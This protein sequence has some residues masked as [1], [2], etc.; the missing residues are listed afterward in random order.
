MSAAPLTI[1]QMQMKY[2]AQVSRLLVQGFRGKFQSLTNMKDDDLALFFEKLL[3]H[4][5]HEPFGRRM[6]VLLEGIVVGTM[7]IQWKGDSDPELKRKPLSWK[8]FNRFGKWNLMK[9]ML[10]LHFLEHKPQAGEC[11]IADL[12]VHSDH[13]GIGVG[14]NLLQWAKQ[15]VQAEP[16]LD[17]LSLFVSG[18]N[19]RARHLYEQLSFHTKFQRSSLARHIFFRERKWN[20]MVLRLK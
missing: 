10:G 1:E 19:E 17:V 18:H 14:T 5:P 15:Y 13:R 11:Y 20:Y 12:V 6:V 2:N 3:D 4:Y 8:S 9:M 16:H 7:S